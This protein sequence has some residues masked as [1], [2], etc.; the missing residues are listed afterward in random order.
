[1]TRSRTAGGKAKAEALAD[2]IGAML[3]YPRI[4]G[5]LEGMM[6]GTGRARRRVKKML[7]NMVDRLR[8]M[9]PQLPPLDRMQMRV[10]KGQIL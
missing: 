1:M 8:T 10:K 6:R 3:N 5:I 2:K 7:R 9:N 4:E